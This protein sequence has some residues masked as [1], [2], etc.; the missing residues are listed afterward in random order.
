LDYS[1]FIEY[2]RLGSLLRKSKLG[3]IQ[4]KIKRKT[5]KNELSIIGLEYGYTGNREALRRSLENLLVSHKI[6]DEEV[7][8]ILQEIEEIPLF[9]EI[10][11]KYPEQVGTGALRKA[12]DALFS[13]GWVKWEKKAS[14][15]L[16]EESF[17]TLYEGSVMGIYKDNGEVRLVLYNGKDYS[18]ITPDKN[19]EGLSY[20]A[21]IQILRPRLIISYGLSRN[22]RIYEKTLDYKLLA[23]L[24]IPQLP[25]GNL[26]YVLVLL[27]GSEPTNMDERLKLFLDSSIWMI[28]RVL[29][30][31]PEL[32][33][34]EL[35]NGLKGLFAP[36]YNARKS[37]F[38]RRLEQ[39]QL[40]NGKF[41]SNEPVDTYVTDTVLVTENINPLQP[42]YSP[43]AVILP[44]INNNDIPESNYA[45]LIIYMAARSMGWW[46]DPLLLL[47]G[48]EDYSEIKEKLETL[49]REKLIYKKT[50]KAPPTRIQV[51]PWD[52]KHLLLLCGRKI[53][54]RRLIINTL[55][56]PGLVL[57]GGNGLTPEERGL[58]TKRFTYSKTRSCIKKVENQGIVYCIDES[59]PVRLS[60]LFPRIDVISNEK[61]L[62]ELVRND[63]KVSS[64]IREKPIVKIYGLTGYVTGFHELATALSSVS[65][66]GT[67]II[68]PNEPLKNLVLLL[69]KKGVV[70][71]TLGDL[72]SN[73]HILI[74]AGRVVIVNPE[75]TFSHQLPPFLYSTSEYKKAFASLLR[76]V[77]FWIRQI[78]SNMEIVLV[79]RVSHD[80]LANDLRTESFMV[81]GEPF[82]LSAEELKKLH[83]DLLERARAIFEE[84]WTSGKKLRLRG[85][86]EKAIGY[87]LSMYTFGAPSLVVTILPTG[88]GKSAVYQVLGKL[89]G[90]SLI[91]LP[92][93]IV[94][95]L[96]T[97]IHDQVKSLRNKGFSAEYIDAGISPKRRSEILELYRNG[98]L[99][100]LYIT[101]E[102]FEDPIV[103]EM[104]APPRRPLFIV[105]DEV[106]T[107]SK[108]GRSFR[109]SYLHMARILIERNKAK[110]RIPLLGFTATLPPG[111]DTDVIKILTGLSIDP[112]MVKV[113]LKDSYRSL[114]ELG[115]HQSRPLIIRGPVIRRELKFDVETVDSVEERRKKLLSILKRLTERYESRKTPYIGIV[116]TGFV[117]S[118]EAKWANVNNVVEMINKS[119]G[120]DMAV[121]YHGSLS[122]KERLGVEEKIYESSETGKPPKIVVATKAFGMGVDIPNIRF[123]VHYMLSESIED[124]YQE[125]GRAGRDGRASYIISLYS[126]KDKELRRRLLEL[127]TIQPSSILR[128]YNLLVELH[129]WL[130]SRSKNIEI[131]PYT[132]VLPSDAFLPVTP[133]KARSDRSAPLRAA[134]RILDIL[135]EHE[136][137][138]YETFTANLPAVKS[139]YDTVVEFADTIYPLIPGVYLVDGRIPKDLSIVKVK[140]NIGR[141]EDTTKTIPLSIECCGS[142]VFRSESFNE[143]Y[144]TS[145]TYGKKS[146]VVIKL[147]P[148]ARFEKQTVLP[149]IIMNYLFRR[150]EEDAERIE[151]LDQMLSEAVKAKNQGKNP[152]KIIKNRIIKYF[153]SKPIKEPEEELFPKGGIKICNRL[154]ECILPVVNDLS[155]LLYSTGYNARRVVLAVSRKEVSDKIL[156]LV[157]RSGLKREPTVTMFSNIKRGYSRRGEL[158]LMD[159]GYIVLVLRED[160][161]KEVEEM[162]KKYPYLYA[163]LYRV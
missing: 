160:K 65:I 15:M 141:I 155:M 27:Y 38:N 85:Y 116:F 83:L 120:K 31:L 149:H 72:I 70:P 52:L 88:A 94:S 151:Y 108:W 157:S 148:E 54:G 7:F 39:V 91:G 121:G 25:S 114:E 95:P 161:H 23:K 26:D 5:L 67:V 107:L 75:K 117:E 113:D 3:S 131:D 139:P 143:S 77:V 64:M 56:N 89:L 100:F 145:V 105:L 1:D 133:V 9:L 119:L 79:S 98:L 142:E 150:E 68:V 127:E 37:P 21:L 22:D 137:L 20:D 84:Y 122:D 159:K 63:F 28:E 45:K 106:H 58:A 51:K 115:W 35:P 138:T 41:I 129:N 47:K 147:N 81:K 109:P 146:Y 134:Q 71:V 53:S 12:R 42:V 130:K 66:P 50:C 104:I 101:P 103:Q 6:T 92:A 154:E 162:T 125:A 118:E 163:Y 57:L 43:Y 73:P 144:R 82:I 136:I 18:V 86:Q 11:E 4:Y 69:G 96:R 99:D 78:V 10:A 32:S 124:Y 123:V 110:P 34:L 87:A 33:K 46:Y 24:A 29:E 8:L 112:L 97:L 128:T 59:F 158:Y 153:S 111:V 126:E 48:L 132:I 55:T 135:A 152:D 40:P 61:V 14:S 62:P 19:S 2:Y 13:R 102:R 74:G 156:E 80:L 30:R 44:D 17:Y 93:M 90:E 16:G 49:I 60:E 76:N 140:Y 36:P